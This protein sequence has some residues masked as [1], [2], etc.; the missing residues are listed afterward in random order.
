MTD[1][2][3]TR[4]PRAQAA[5]RLIALLDYFDQL[6]RAATTK[7]ISSALEVPQS[8]ASELLHVLCDL[9]L[10]HRNDSD[11]SY[12]PSARAALLGSKFQPASVRSGELSAVVAEL[13][14]ETQLP[15]VIFGRVGLH[16]QVFSCRGHASDLRLAGHKAPLTEAVPGWLLLSGEEPAV[17]ARLLHASRALAEPRCAIS[18]TVLAARL[19][20]VEQQGFLHGPLGFNSSRTICAVLIGPA[21]SERPL[22]LGAVLPAES[23]G[24]SQALRA[25]L[26]RAIS[27]LTTRPLRRSAQVRWRALSDAD[28]AT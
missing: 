21:I 25:R 15:I 6:G 16:A 11:R 9:G 24:D 26:Q 27:R 23:D 19:E 14:G 17:R 13:H 10:L 3:L 12:A 4:T 22:V 18:S 28:T 7:E 8:S 20:S 1:A 5:R 2:R